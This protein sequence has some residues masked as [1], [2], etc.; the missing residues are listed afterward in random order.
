MTDKPRGLKAIPRSIWALGLVSLLMDASS[1]LVH[2]LLPAFLTVTLGASVFS[3]GLIEGLAEATASITKIFSG[4]LSDFLGKRKFLTVIGYGL[5]AV[6]KPLFPLASSVGMVFT[7]RFI[8]RVGKGIRGAPRDALIGDLAP[9]HLRGA[10]FGL[11]QTLDTVGAF[12][13]PL[14]ALLFMA[15]FAGN[16]RA[17]FWIAL[18]PAA[19]CVLVLIF[20]VQEPEASAP[21]KAAR[22]PIRWAELHNLGRPFWILIFI[23]QV[24]ML[25]RMS[26][27]FFLLK[28]QHTGLRL[29]YI[30]LVLVVYNVVYAASAYPA[31]ALSDRLSRKH[32][33]AFGISLFVL[34]DLA[35]ALATSLW[36]VTLG[37]VLWGLHMGIANSLLSAMVADQAPAR[38]RGTAFGIL[39]LAMGLGLLAASAGAGYLWDRFGPEVTFLASAAVT[40]LAL[41]CL[42]LLP[43]VKEPQSHAQH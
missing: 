24:L 32:V 42:P 18:I 19:L 13:G 40:A 35:L 12:L 36:G 31:G 30:P 2:S 1:E 8:D 33:L 20:G 14:L 15:L 21:A 10:S 27:A 5:A 41:F 29:A 3:V 17:V 38:L 23:T 11:R 39:N 37:V 26:E 22:L 7:A 43:S 6:S 9:P 4:T 28:A 34:A 25:A 16:I